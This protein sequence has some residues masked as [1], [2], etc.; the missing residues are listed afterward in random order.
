M[1]AEEEAQL[2][3]TRAEEFWMRWNC[4]R[5]CRCTIKNRITVVE[6]WENGATCWGFCD[7]RNQTEWCLR[8]RTWK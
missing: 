5:F 3:T 4:V 8:S 6:P 7:T 1:N 2:V